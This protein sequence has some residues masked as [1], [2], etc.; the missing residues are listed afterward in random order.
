[1]IY[2]LINN[3]PNAAEK[4]AQVGVQRK[5]KSTEKYTKNK[6]FEFPQNYLKSMITSNAEFLINDTPSNGRYNNSASRKHN[7]S[8]SKK[9]RSAKRT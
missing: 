4:S 7:R 8:S 5:S 6:T 2:S 3:I 1:M 9:K